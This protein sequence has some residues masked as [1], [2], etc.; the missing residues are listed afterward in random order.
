M[1]TYGVAVHGAGWVAGAHV[2][3][4]QADRRARVVAVSS[5]REA[6]ARAVAQA[7][8]LDSAFIST[9]LAEVLARDDVQ[10]L[11]VCTPHDLHPHDTVA[12]AAASK[13][14]LIEKPAAL[15]L[16]AL[17]AMRDAV[18][19]A[20]VKTVV[21]FVLRWNPLFDLLKNQ[22][23]AGAFGRIYL[24]EVDY[25][26]GVG[27]WYGQFGWS[28]T[29]AQGRSSF[30]NAGCHAVD[31]L[32][33]FPE[34]GTV[35]VS[36]YAVEGSDRFEYPGTTVMLCKFANGA[37]GKSLSNIDAVGPYHFNVA[38][39]GERGNALNNR[40]FSPL[41]GGQTDY[42]EV[43]TIL[44]DSGDVTHHPFNPEMSHLLDCIGQDVESPLSLENTLN[45]HEACLAA[46]IS[47]AEGRAVQ[48][49]L[50]A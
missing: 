44:P 23:A 13:H 39:Y 10:I 1:S 11:S 18:R 28:R 36:A 5:R 12:A 50:P 15:D 22:I 34:S 43:P 2:A 31:A 48:L 7:A 45:T 35:E 40:I 37:L 33:Y 42:A 27:P 46:D 21:G 49:P 6:S 30:L 24:A 20:A 47:A 8:G 26:H 25:I 19:Q 32:R 14:V 16:P 4:W 3:A 17:R 9:D 41:L 38:L 29:A